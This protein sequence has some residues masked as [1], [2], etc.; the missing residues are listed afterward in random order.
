MTTAAPRSYFSHLECPVC[1]QHYSGREPT[2]VCTCGRPLLARYDLASV[3]RYVR[4]G[5]AM[6]RRRDLWRYR[7]LLPVLDETNVITLGE[8]GT[9]LLQPYGDV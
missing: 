7:E 8:G 6:R 4:R 9:P 5:D 2:N 1:G 3:Q